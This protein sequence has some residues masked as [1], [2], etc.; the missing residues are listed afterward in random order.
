[1]SWPRILV[2]YLVA[3]LLTF[4]LVG[5]DRDATVAEEQSAATTTPFLEAV[6]ERIDRVRMEDRSM[7]VQFERRDG[8]WITTEPEGL[9]PPGDV[10]DAVLE[11]FTSLPAIEIVA[12]GV[13]HEG[14]FGLVPPSARVRIEQEGA[15]VSTIVLG[16]LS[17]T[18]TAV[19]ARKSGK[20]EV[21]LIGLNA[22][23]YLDLVFENI[24]RQRGSVG[25]APPANGIA[26][27]ADG[28]A[29]PPVE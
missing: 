27:P 24:R 9:A 4:H 1:M 6:P 16:D 7:A 25:T 22:K 14:Q 21:A 3:A 10:V 5:K 11:S 19:Y 20:D 8:R 26:V 12:T 23:Y 28:A 17:P 29:A 15:V 18:R 13:E 2:T